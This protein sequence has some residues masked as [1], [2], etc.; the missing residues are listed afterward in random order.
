[1]DLELV[2]IKEEYYSEFVNFITL[3]EPTYLYLL[4]LNDKT[5]GYGNIAKQNNK[6]KNVLYI[7][8]IEQY[9]GNGYG[10]FLFKELLKEAKNF[11]YK[12]I[13]LYTN[14]S[15]LVMRRLITN[16]LGIK[17][18]QDNDISEYIIPLFKILYS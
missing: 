15:D 2:K 18:S 9:R 6:E 4:K 1:M 8:I 14:S 16:N 11:G 12:D 17:I 5:I 10:K 3:K 7:Y 13:T